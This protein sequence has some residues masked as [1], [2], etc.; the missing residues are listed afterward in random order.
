MHLVGIWTTEKYFAAT[1]YSCH[2]AI[3]DL[4]TIMR[5]TIGNCIMASGEIT[6]KSKD[7]E[8]VHVP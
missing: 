7:F 6:S 3:L 5:S 4:N 8:G 2:E 1:P